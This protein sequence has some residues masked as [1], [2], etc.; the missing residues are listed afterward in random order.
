VMVQRNTLVPGAISH[1]FRPM[2]SCAEVL[3][4]VGGDVEIDGITPAS[5]RVLP[6]YMFVAL[7]GNCK[8]GRSGIHQALQQGAIAV[9]AEWA[10]EDLPENLPWGTFTYIRVPSATNAWFWLCKYWGHL[11]K[12]GTDPFR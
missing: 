7:G 10:P 3:D 8:E 12:L 4:W 9:L 2:G 6:G 1:L 5:Q 11:C